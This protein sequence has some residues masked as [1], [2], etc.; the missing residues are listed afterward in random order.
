MG[1]LLST[2]GATG[3]SAGPNSTTKPGTQ[4]ISVNPNSLEFRIPVDRLSEFLHAI[5]DSQVASMD[6]QALLLLYCLT[7]RQKGS[8]DVASNLV[9]PVG[10]TKTIPSP[11]A[12]HPTSPLTGLSLLTSLS[13]TALKGKAGLDPLETTTRD[14]SSP[15]GLEPLGGH[16]TPKE[17]GAHR[18]APIPDAL[19][20]EMWKHYNGP[21]YVSRCWCCDHL[22]E[23]SSFEAGHVKSEHDGGET[24]LDNL[25]PVCSKCN[26]SMST[27]HMKTFAET[28]GFRGRIVTQP[29]VSDMLRNLTASAAAK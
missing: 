5:G 29:N 9:Q 27:K 14:L 23:V 18:K 22:L 20:F 12:H 19:R 3:G 1:C 24:C 28:Y 26:K 7:Q 11:I 21:N 4:P 6:Q 17:A 13:A 2:S 15:A 8:L 25:R 16:S 10:E